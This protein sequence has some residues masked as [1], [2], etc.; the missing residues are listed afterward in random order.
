MDLVKAEESQILTLYTDGKGLDPLIDSVREAVREFNHDLTTDKGRKATA[1]LAAKVS[2]AK[3]F[4]DG[5]GKDLV[6][7]WK[8]KS[9]VVD[10][11]RKSMRD[12]L[13]ALR[14][15]ARAPLTA[16]ENAEKA[17]LQALEESIERLKSYQERLEDESSSAY[18]NKLDLLKSITIDDSY[19]E[20]KAEA[21][22]IKEKAI[23]FLELKIIDQEKVEAERAELERLRKEAEARAKADEE[24]RLRKE[25]EERTKKE[26]D[27]KIK[28]AFERAEAEK[29][30]AI[31]ESHRQE[32]DARRKAEA[33]EY[34]V[35][36]A[37]ERA[38]Q[39][40]ENAR[41]KLDQEAKAKADADAKREANAKH[42]KKIK[43][44]A[45]TALIELGID[46]KMAVKIVMAIDENKIPN[47]TIHY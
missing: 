3:T 45:K 21:F 19:E 20:R 41:L 23:T 31:E 26:A 18:R 4:L 27:E 15:E 13:D 29:Q 30:K 43:T 46:E 6:S 17:R 25:G 35:N 12:E 47:V 2:K 5:L 14:D 42:N 38:K 40:E 44:E 37:E 32:L 7:D 11:V 33:Q 9:K 22:E 8:E 16:W 36:Q 1:S 24:E 28:A 34:A 39:A 10:S